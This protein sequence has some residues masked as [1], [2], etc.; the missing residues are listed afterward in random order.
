MQGAASLET[1]FGRTACVVLVVLGIS[2]R[3]ACAQGVR[4]DAVSSARYIEV[5]PL[6]LDSVPIT[7]VTR[8]E[9]GRFLFEGQPVTCIPGFDV[10]TRYVAG[11][12]A[13]ATVLAQDV[14]LTAWGLGV[15]GLSATVSLR[16]RADAGGSFVWPRS[17][18]AFDAMLA[19]AE[20]DRGRWRVRLGRQRTHGGLGFSG[21]DGASALFQPLQRLTLEAF[22]G[23][24]LARGLYEPRHEALRGIEDFLPDR[25]AFLFGGVAAGEPWPGTR[26]AARYQRE[27]WSDRSALLSERAAVDFT[28]DRVPRVLLDGAADWDFAFGRV[29]KAHVTARAPL[30]LW[31]SSVEATARRYVPYFELWTI[32]GYFSPVS[33]HE[34]EVRARATP[35]RAATLSAYAGYRVYADAHTT[36]VLTP[37]ID[38]AFRIGASARVLVRD[39]LVFEGG[40]DMERGFGAFLSSG[41]VALTWSPQDRLTV[42]LDGSA[43][44]Q[45]EEFRVGEGVV[46]GGGGGV[47]FKIGARSGVGAG[48][49]LYRQT[50]DNRPGQ[51]DWNQLRAWAMLRL[52]IGRDPGL[53]EPVGS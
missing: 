5:R 25:E 49:H 6:L 26:I 20:L 8:T 12:V 39:D 50:F 17:D 53:R 13:H 47:D 3:S 32:W 15:A 29:G 16:V 2:A 44:Q 21:Y 1:F 52:G 18:D 30:P 31:S 27:I 36:V 42:S 22:G 19:Y 38:D 24:S 28:T 9:D 45:I 35:W 48:V 33:Y 43:L 23:R 46:Y 14:A 7:S 37:L 10:C 40:Y 11:D 41:D 34:A 4:G 51:P